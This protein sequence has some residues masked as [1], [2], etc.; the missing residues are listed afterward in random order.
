[1]KLFSLGQTEVRV[2]LGLFVV[3]AVECVKGELY[4]LMMALIALV[5]HEASHAII[6]RNV[7]CEVTSITVY[8]F[9]AEA[10][11]TAQRQ[12]NKALAMI[13]AAGP[14]ASLIFAGLSVLTITAFPVTR[15]GLEAFTL[16]N[17]VL[18]IFNLMPAYPLDGGR[19]LFCALRTRL[20]DRTAKAIAAWSGL[21]IG[22]ALLA[23]ALYCTLFLY[24]SLTLYM[25]GAFLL[26]AAAK[27]ILSLPSA[28]LMASVTK[29]S[30]VKRGET[31]R[32]RFTAVHSKMSAGDALHDLSSN[33]YNLLRVVD[34]RMHSMG[35]LD[36][37]ALIAGI[38]RLG[39]TA[40]VGEILRFDQS[41]SL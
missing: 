23:L 34:D 40:T 30:A 33:N 20:R 19:L 5:L 2:H 3:I 17:V 16:Y 35:E 21:L 24:S 1:M 10:R 39:M 14:I 41:D 11:I 28:L 37:G 7:D 31:V 32:V 38:G 25:M 36:E 4:E 26:F 15:T 22:C 29:S 9:G 18:F 12:Q 8:P 13:A 6:A 27:E